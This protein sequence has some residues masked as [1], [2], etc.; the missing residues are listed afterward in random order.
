MWER[1]F[2]IAMRGIYQIF[3]LH[4]LG[5]GDWRNPITC[6]F[7]F[8]A[9][10]RFPVRIYQGTSVQMSA[11]SYGADG[12]SNLYSEDGMRW[13]MVVDDRTGGKEGVFVREEVRNQEQIEKIQACVSECS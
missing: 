12:M 7:L 5:R 10:S 8:Y 1:A 3:R 2:K 9:S 6:Y 11:R 13:M 4:F